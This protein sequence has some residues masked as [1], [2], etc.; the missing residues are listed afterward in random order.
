[1]AKYYARNT[2]KKPYR[3]ITS[4]SIENSEFGSDPFC[5][6]KIT[7]VY[8]RLLKSYLLDYCLGKKSK[9]NH[10][11]G[12]YALTSKIKLNGVSAAFSQ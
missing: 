5:S 6:T 3:A 2:G 7:V 1:M 4:N 9:Q 8:P 11:S 12:G 10:N